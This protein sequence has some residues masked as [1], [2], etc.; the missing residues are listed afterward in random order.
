MDLAKDTPIPGS[1]SVT[2]AAPGTYEFHCLI[3]PFMHA[4]VQ[5]T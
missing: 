5:V 4:T 3:H 2:F 1:N